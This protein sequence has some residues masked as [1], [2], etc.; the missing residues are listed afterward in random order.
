MIHDFEQTFSACTGLSPSQWY[1]LL[2]RPQFLARIWA[3]PQSRVLEYEN[4][5]RAHSGVTQAGIPHGN[6]KNGIRLQ[7]L[8]HYGCRDGSGAKAAGSRGS[9]ISDKIASLPPCIFCTITNN[10]GYRQCTE[11]GS[12]RQPHVASS[13]SK[14][15]HVSSVFFGFSHVL[16]C[17]I[18][19][20]NDDIHD[21][22]KQTQARLVR[23]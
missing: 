18:S 5:K 21:S 10:N 23:K 13:S 3:V 15:W 14:S 19:C 7:S 9:S 8:V 2:H 4:L 16:L 17:S 22:E 6:F 20:S 1:F 12:E 11:F